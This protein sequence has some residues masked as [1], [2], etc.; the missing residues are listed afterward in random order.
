MTREDD[1][2]LRFLPKCA[3]IKWGCQTY[4]NDKA[5]VRS[6]FRPRRCRWS[7]AQRSATRYTPSRGANGQWQGTIS[8]ASHS[9]SMLC[10]GRKMFMCLFIRGKYTYAFRAMGFRY[11]EILAWILNGMRFTHWLNI[12]AREIVKLKTVNP[13]ERSSYGRIST[14]YLLITLGRQ[15]LY[16]NGITHVTIKG[17]YAIWQ[18]VS[19]TLLTWFYFDIQHLERVISRSRTW[20]FVNILQNVVNRTFGVLDEPRD[21][22]GHICYVPM[23]AMNACAS[24]GSPVCE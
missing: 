13:F 7:P 9:I 3:A 23:A 1:I 11:L 20:T 15:P 19:N 17:E 4:S 14:V 22:K 6:S 2:T 10:W 18:A 16:G 12:R 24:L 5:H 8:S 21:L